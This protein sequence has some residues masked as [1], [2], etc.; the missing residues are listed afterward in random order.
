MRHNI[1][2]SASAPSA[3]SLTNTFFF[4]AED[5]IRDLIVTGVQTCALP[6]SSAPQHQHTHREHYPT[7]R[8]SPADQ[9]DTPSPAAA[10][11]QSL[12][13]RPVAHPAQPPSPHHSPRQPPRCKAAPPYSPD[14]SALQHPP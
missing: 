8:S 5:G 3:T 11:P 7:G 6:I 14:P 13:H 9:P 4:Q 12:S 10:T 1:S 2:T